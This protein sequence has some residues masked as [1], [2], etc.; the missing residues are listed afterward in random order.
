MTLHVPVMLDEVLALFSEH[1]AAGQGGQY[2]TFVDATLGAGGHAYAILEKFEN[3]CLIGF[4]QD[5]RARGI[6]KERLSPFSGRVRILPQNFS[7]IGELADSDEN[8][9]WRGAD[10]VL[11]DLGVSSMQL[12]TPER[13]FSYQDDGPLDMRMDR[14]GGAL[15]AKELLA[16]FDVRELSRI[17]RDFGEERHAFQIAKAI[18]RSRERGERMEQT[19]DLVALI[20]RTLPAPVQRKMGT[21]PARRVFQALRIEVNGELEVLREGLEGAGKVCR[22]GGVIVVISYHSLEDRIV[23]RAFMEWSKRG[24]GNVLTRRPLLPGEDEIERNRSSRSA[25]LRAFVISREGSTAK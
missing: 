16:R 17:F 14:Q 8:G 5:D 6:A 7:R 4:D 3:S 13:G 12:A 21:H 10:G 22:D 9:G 25:K 20:R 23:K 2:P 19:S 18:V 11:F 24:D 15:S 1:L